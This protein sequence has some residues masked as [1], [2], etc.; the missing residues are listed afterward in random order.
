MG[1]PYETPECSANLWGVGPACCDGTQGLYGLGV[2][3]NTG[4]RAGARPGRAGNTSLVHGVYWPG[5]G[6][7][8]SGL[9]LGVLSGYDWPVVHLSHGG[10]VI[11][12]IEHE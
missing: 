1:D 7:L 10:H 8:F 5:G 6:H 12:P 9:L 2:L 3:Q 11:L 4:Q